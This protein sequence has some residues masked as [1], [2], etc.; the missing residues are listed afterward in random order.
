MLFVPSRKI[1]V[2]NSDQTVG[3]GSVVI[4]IG[5]LGANS[6]TLPL[7]QQEHPNNVVKGANKDTKDDCQ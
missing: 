7:G 2:G 3:V 1:S 5:D 4:D 6:I